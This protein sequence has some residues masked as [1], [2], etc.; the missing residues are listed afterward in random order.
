MSVASLYCT[1]ML[2]TDQIHSAWL[3]LDDPF[4]LGWKL[5]TSTNFTYT[6]FI[7]IHQLEL[8]GE[9]NGLP[10][11]DWQYLTMDSKHS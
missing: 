11:W 3:E 1:Q 5:Q 10:L 4:L 9:A 7:K 8:K 6:D 2:S